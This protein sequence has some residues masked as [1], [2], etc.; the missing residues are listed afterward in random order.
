MRLVIAWL[1]IA[2]SALVMQE[3]ETPSGTFCTPAGVVSDGMVM[4]DP[5]HPCHCEHMTYSAPDCEG[6][7]VENAHCS[8][9][10]H[11]DKCRCPVVCK[12]PMPAP[13]DQ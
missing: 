2:I 5:S 6:P 11:K 1:W 10:C 4:L 13:E 8:N 3:R 7:V 9:Y 12:D